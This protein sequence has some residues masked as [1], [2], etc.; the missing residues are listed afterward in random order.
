VVVI[1]GQ[2]SLTEMGVKADFVNAVINV[3]R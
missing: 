1:C 2:V 3:M